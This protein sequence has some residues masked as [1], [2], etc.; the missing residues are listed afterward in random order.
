VTDE[1]RGVEVDGVKGSLDCLID[2][3]VVDVKSA[4]TRGM[5]KFGSISDLIR[6]DP[7]GYERQVSGYSTAL[8]RK[9]GF[10]FAVGKEQGTL[11]LLEVPTCDVHE[12]I[13]ELRESLERDEPPVKCYEPVEDGKSGNLKLPVG[14][15]YCPHKFECHKDTNE[16]EGLR[17]FIYS[18]GPRYLTQVKR[19]PDVYEVK[20]E[21]QSIDQ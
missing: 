8:G 10:L 1:Q 3:E 17:T 12:K 13:K 4:S 21:S 7:F 16:G 6:D 19:V 9:R 20:K 15:S 18:T 5:S 2:G 14:C 11:K